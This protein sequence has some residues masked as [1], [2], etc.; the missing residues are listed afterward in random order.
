[1][2]A[3]GRHHQEAAAGTAAPL[4]RDGPAPPPLPDWLDLVP[5][6]NRAQLLAMKAEERALTLRTIA[7]FY[8]FEAG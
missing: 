1:M 4:A 2:P 5:G 8:G 6:A 3:E 7:R